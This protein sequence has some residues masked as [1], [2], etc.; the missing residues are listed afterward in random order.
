MQYLNE[1]PIGIFDSGYGGLTILSE[2]EKLL[3][4][5]DFLYLGDNSRAPYGSRSFEIIYQYTREAVFT[6]FQ[7]GC[8]LVILA[9]NTASAKALR[10]IQQRD[11][12]QINPHKRVLGIIRPTAE[13]VGAITTTHHVGILGTEG[14]IQSQ[15]YPMEIAKTHPHITV[16]GQAC[17]MWVPLVENGYS[18]SVGADYFIQKDVEA[19]LQ[20]D[21]LIDTVILACTHYPL[22]QEK[23]RKYLPKHISLISQGRYIAQSLQEYLTRHQELEEACSKNR[24]VTYL[25][26]ESPEKFQH[27]SQLFLGKEVLAQK[28]E[29]DG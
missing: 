5:Y 12:P 4:Q 9:C 28:I 1:G 13:V 2:I 3:P 17:P 16:V 27:H 11:L 23:I 18:Q 20:R 24:T 10:T 21:P 15:S 26:T 6:L 19:L 14:T 7:K 8:N 29:W 25:T 22:L